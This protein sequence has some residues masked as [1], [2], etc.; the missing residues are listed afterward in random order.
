M[1]SMSFP[2]IA[3]DMDNDSDGQGFGERN[4]SS[5][6]GKGCDIDD[7]REDL[8]RT[9]QVRIVVYEWGVEVVGEDIVTC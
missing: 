3:T 9:R 2:T 1:S 8:F 7:L 5:N 4:C 6:I